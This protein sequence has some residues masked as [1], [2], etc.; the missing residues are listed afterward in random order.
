MKGWQQR[1]EQ[2]R[3]EEQSLRRLCLH[4]ASH[5]CANLALGVN[6]ERVVIGRNLDG[7]GSMQLRGLCVWRTNGKNIPPE[8]LI[9]TLMAGP[10]SDRFFFGVEPDGYDSSDHRD[11]RQA[12]EQLAGEGRGDVNSDFSGRSQGGGEIGS[13]TLGGDRGACPR[14]VAGP[15]A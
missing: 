11:A 13:A 6:V 3:R 5:A 2:R 15:L 10:A 14:A 9:I 12:A 8:T 1:Y 4:E 7:G